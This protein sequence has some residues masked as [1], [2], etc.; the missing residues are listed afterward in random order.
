[1]K[2]EGPWDG[3]ERSAEGAERPVEGIKVKRV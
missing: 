3:P 2:E 1:M